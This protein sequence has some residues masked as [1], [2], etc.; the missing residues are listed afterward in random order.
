MHF[1]G[2]NEPDLFQ[3][4]ASTVEKAQDFWSKMGKLFPAVERVVLAG[5]VPRRELPPPPGEFDEAYATIETVVNCAPPQIVVC[6][7]FNSGRPSDRQHFTL[8]QVSSSLQPKWQV[9]DEDWAP[10]RVLLP[11]KKFSASPLG[12][13]MTFLRRNSHLTLE[14][15]GVDQ[16]KIETY[17]RYA[18]N[19][20]IRCPYLDCDATFPR[21]D[22]WERHLEDSSHWRL[23][24]KFGYEGE[25]IMELL[26]FKHTPE[27]VKSAIEAR[28]KRIEAALRQ[29][30]RL[31]RR[32]GCG[33]SRAGTEQRRLFEEQYFAQLREENFV[34]PG[35]FFRGPEDSYNVWIDDLDRY[36]DSTYLYY[37]S[38]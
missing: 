18:V 37:A 14:I 17:A 27:A 1:E 23:G 32:V 6:I 29:A 30:R 9:L 38:E 8:W 24:P 19:G 36:F 26:Y 25:H 12:D 21:R 31:E 33:W 16:L 13:L 35:E 7:A 20:V 5:C 22:Q 3:E 28:E 15:R 4:Q 10:R 2:D 11:S 34:S